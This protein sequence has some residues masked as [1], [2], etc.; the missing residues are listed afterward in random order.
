MKT[1]AIIEHPYGDKQPEFCLLD[2][3]YQYLDGL[4]VNR[5]DMTPEEEKLLVDIISGKGHILSPVP[6]K[7]WDFCINIGFIY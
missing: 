6:P 7:E 5:D 1:L 3:D 4:Y 2:G